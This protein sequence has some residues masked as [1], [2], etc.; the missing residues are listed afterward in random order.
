MEQKLERLLIEKP[1]ILQ[2]LR[3]V[4]IGVLNTALDFIILNFI[5]KTLGIDS[6]LKLGTINVFG[7]AAALVQ[8]YYWNRYWTFAGGITNVIQNF[9][10]LVVIGG[11]GGVG[12]IAVIVGAKMNASPLFYIIIL[13]LFLVVQISAW[14][15]FGIGNNQLQ[16]STEDRRHQLT[17]FLLVSII[18]I[19]INSVIVAFISYYLIELAFFQQNADLIKNAAKVLATFV[20]LVW[21]FLGYK[22]IVFKK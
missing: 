21:N 4:A 20:S 12:F 7:T 18:G 6:G 13:V 22:L 8:S 19:V 17:T 16:I 15:I 11:T 3:F 5:S 14:S 1:V 2:I 9:W 10:R